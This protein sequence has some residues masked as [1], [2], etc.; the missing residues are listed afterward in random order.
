MI[1]ESVFKSF[2]STNELESVLADKIAGQLQDAV[3][4]RGKA[5][6]IVSGGSTPLKL[7]QLLSKKAIDWSEVYIT[8]ADER[9]VESDEKDSNERLVRE[10]L[11]QNRAANAKFRGLKNMFATPEQG[12]AMT[13]ES[14]ANFPRPF[15]VV[16]LGMGTDGH[17]CSWF[18]CSKELDNALTSKELCAAVNPTTAPHPR[19]TLTQDAILAS[20]QIYLH[21][22]GEAKLTVYKKALLNEN[23]KE[24]PIRAVLAQ[25][26]APVDVFYSA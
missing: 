14:L 5:S 12:C 25:R 11:L 13:S 22:V 19:I 17:T 18:P 9:W 23:V 21:L 26:K 16:V 6:L 15:D 10:N 24:M 20:R 4:S 8:L 2:D 1:K 7:F 3:D